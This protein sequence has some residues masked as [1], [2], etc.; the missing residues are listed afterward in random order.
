M[1]DQSVGPFFQLSVNLRSARS[2]GRVPRTAQ[3]VLALP[4][5]GQRFVHSG[6]GAC[7][8][9]GLWAVVVCCWLNLLHRMSEIQENLY[10]T[11]VVP[12]LLCCGG[13]CG[14]L[15]HFH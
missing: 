5:S 9:D 3:K 11:L 8:R 7:I 6:R 14:G 15:P 1:P 10:A 13:F 12:F 2:W 4:P